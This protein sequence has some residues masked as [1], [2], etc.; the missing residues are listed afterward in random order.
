MPFKIALAM[1]IDMNEDSP[2]KIKFK[3]MNFIFLRLDI[4][5]LVQMRSLN[6][7][8]LGACTAAESFFYNHC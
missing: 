5:K 7:D 6:A 1:K 3:L 2:P 8:F 4:S